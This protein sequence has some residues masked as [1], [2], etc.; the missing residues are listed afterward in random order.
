MQFMNPKE[1]RKNPRIPSD[2]IVEITHEN[3]KTPPFES[4]MVNFS[5]EGAFIEGT[6]IAKPGTTI[7]LKIKIPVTHKIVEISAAIM[8]EGM[9]EGVVGYG[10]GFLSSD[11][12]NLN[13]LVKYFEAH[14]RNLHHNRSV[15]TDLPKSVKAEP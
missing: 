1:R 3:S 7:R 2:I 12:P 5:E 10:L 6:P 9:S 11:H 14:F 4:K 15:E 13:V 8:W